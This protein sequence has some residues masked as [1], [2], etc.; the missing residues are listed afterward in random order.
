MLARKN[1]Y[2]SSECFQVLVD[3]TRKYPSLIYEFLPLLEPSIQ[4]LQTEPKGLSALVY[5]IGEFAQKIEKAPYLLDY[6]LRLE[7]HNS[8]FAYAILLSGCK[9]FFK[10]PGEG[11]EVLGKIFGDIL[12]NYKEVDLRDRV[13][14]YYNLLKTSVSLAE[15]IISPS[16]NS[17][18]YF[19]SSFDEEFI[20]QIFTE[21]NSLS[22]IYRK[23]EEKFNKY[24]AED[25]VEEDDLEGG[26]NEGNNED[27]GEGEAE[28]K[29]KEG[30]AKF[31]ESTG[32]GGNEEK[33]NE[34]ES[35]DLLGGLTDF[36][37]SGNNGSSGNGIGEINESSLL[38]SYEINEHDY[39]NYWEKF[40][41]WQHPSYKMI[42]DEVDVE[43]YVNYLK[44]KNIFTK[45]Y[46]NNS[47]I[48]TLFL[49]SCLSQ[50]NTIFL[51][52]LTMNTKNLTIDYEL[53][54]QDKES[55][56]KFNIYFYENVSPLIDQ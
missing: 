44:S 32:F 16:Q 19:Y 12:K 39:Q 28:G 33:K 42:A 2:I 51:C 54:C 22:V 6:L 56:D 43:E 47:G 52:K 34:G 3:L 17:V 14:H 1:G 55:A 7:I 26:E 13:Y 29:S 10:N 49:Y 11:K 21:F 31:E 5:L 53:K 8:E 27:G 9:V 15:S 46:G 18:D 50:N 48:N 30:S 45:A 40:T 36:V 37:G 25:F 41:S 35:V 23:P 38:S 24:V 20:D 4:T